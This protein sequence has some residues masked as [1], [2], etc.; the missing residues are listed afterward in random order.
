MLP[1]DSAASRTRFFAMAMGCPCFIVAVICFIFVILNGTTAFFILGVLLL[2]LSAAGC[3]AG[4]CY[5]IHCAPPR[6]ED[7]EAPAAAAPRV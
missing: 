5:A 1:T 2:I 3:G 4:C 6:D 7:V